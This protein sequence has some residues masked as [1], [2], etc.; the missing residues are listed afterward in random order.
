VT[1]HERPNHAPRT[2]PSPKPAHKA[3]QTHAQNIHNSFINK[4]L[5][6]LCI[7]LLGACLLQAQTPAPADPA[8]ADTQPATPKSPPPKFKA[9]LGE[10]ILKDD[11]IY[12]AAKIAVWVEGKTDMLLL[13][14]DA[15]FS[16]G[17]FGFRGDKMLIRM[18]KEPQP[19]LPIKHIAVYIENA[20]PLAGKGPIT[21]EGAH[22]LVTAS[23]TGR[24]VIKTY[25]LSKE[26]ILDNTFV[27]AGKDRINRFY[28]ELN[29][30]VLPVPAGGPM[31]SREMLELRHQRRTEIRKE[32][33]A[34]DL[35][36]IRRIADSG[37]TKPV[38]APSTTQPVTPRPITTSSDPAA[39]PGENIVIDPETGNPIQLVGD[40]NILPNGS[41]LLFV[42]DKY[43]AQ[44]GKPGEYNL[45]LLGQAR[46]MYLD[47]TNKINATLSADKVVVFI[48]ADAAASVAQRKI[49]SSKILGVYLEDN[50]I[51]S[52]NDYTIRAPRVY[53]DNQFNKASILQ[54][55][56]YAFDIKK[57]LPIYIRAQE[58]RQ[59][60]RT[61]WTANDATL[62][63]SAFYEPHISLAAQKLIFNVEPA[64]E[65]APAPG[66]PG[67]STGMPGL[68]G[69]EPVASTQPTT[70]PTTRET[71]MQAMGFATSNGPDGA[72]NAPKFTF[73]AKNT[74]IK[75]GQTPI[76]V[77]PSLKG[78][79][80]TQ[81]PNRGVQV[82]YS[83]R[84]GPLLETRWD[85]WALTGLDPI[86]GMSAM[87][88]FDYMG[89]NGPGFG[90]E[91]GW[92]T[93]HSYGSLNAYLLAYD[94]GNDQIGNRNEVDFDG[95]Q[96]G[97]IDLKHRELL[98]SEWEASFEL[99]YGGGKTF[100]ERFF[101]D[102]AD[103]SKPYET[104]V[105]LKQQ[106]D[107]ASF[108]FLTKY[109]VN[110][111]K[112]NTQVLQVP[113]YTV[114]KLPELGYYRVGTSLF[115]DRA[116]YYTENRL[117]NMRARPGTDSPSDRGFTDAQSLSQFGFLSNTPWDQYY[118][119][120]GVP[121]RDIARLD[122]RHEI[123]APFKM[124]FLDASPY[125]SGRVTAYD[126]EFRDYLGNGQYNQY[127]LWGAVGSRFSTK[128]SRSYD[129]I[130][131]R[132]LDMNRLNHIAEPNADIF[133]TGSTV[134][135]GNIPIYDPDVEGIQ[136][137]SGFKAG[138]RNTFQTQR[139][140]AGRWRSV[141]WLTVN[142]D[143]IKQ[144]ST[145]NNNQTLARYFSY[146]PEYSTG[147]DHFHSDV[148]WAISDS[149]SST[150][151]ITYNMEDDYVSQYRGGIVM[152]H[153]A[154]LSTFIDYNKVDRID[155][156][157]MG[158]GF[159]YKL[160][161][162]YHVTYRQ[163]YDFAYGQTRGIELS[164]VRK[165]Q[166]FRF[167]VIT[168]YDVINDE[169]VVGFSLIPEGMAGDRKYVNP[170]NEAALPQ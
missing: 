110:N 112:Q 62:T 82:G 117:S 74:Q 149:L 164:V 22:L 85:V 57:N 114:D 15:V 151:E 86:P 106:K 13:E 47:R 93:S 35:K 158:F 6:L 170:F 39:A 161:P 128:F 44:P 133:M 5:A 71:P 122:S 76:F 96:R 55:V 135:D 103:A 101:P 92:E 58:L 118:E 147:G 17:N 163:T 56:M 30:P 113:G 137:S 36:A 108:T 75:V 131:S 102:Q 142:T 59:E 32:R 63:T 146:Q 7:T 90:L 153:D 104:S 126:S 61:Q 99:G 132:I 160:T 41:Q 72:S 53:Y 129:N 109:D 94:T 136:N 3:R 67:A 123:A 130:D 12:N 111:A 143:Y 139:G 24:P 65:M 138:L 66:T 121:T 84:R 73:E 159:N 28:A 98:S 107:D 144:N 79:P 77:W 141:D 11:A 49:D 100:L 69:M 25:S 23:T 37:T 105:Y 83:N 87:A 34:D 88:N 33:N 16:I 116:T 68:P 119:S 154:S 120:I 51:V 167:V 1:R 70:Q 78:D 26:P 148:L 29:E 54:A 10:P 42:A 168:R 89:R 134:P 115:D 64:A 125:A 150:G 9:A 20:K 155:S 157:L 48:K 145:A 50:V 45:A 31:F 97:F 46:L 2:Q 166:Q 124:G 19:G 4:A 18:D 40:K 52:V 43:I 81:T 140:G 156:D 27:N 169:F 162:K 21:A 152:Q 127:R 14:Q 60:S 165:L 38:P 95:A 8:P 91:T 80:T